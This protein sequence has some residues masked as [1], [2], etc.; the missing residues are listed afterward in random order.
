[1]DDLE[2]DFLTFKINCL[3]NSNVN[4][5]TSG[6]TE[7]I[8][9]VSTIPD[10][11]YKTLLLQKIKQHLGV[12]NENLF[13]QKNEVKKK[14]L[15][16]IEHDPI[17]LLEREIIRLLL[18]YFNSEDE[19]VLIGKYILQETKD[20]NL[21]NS[22]H[23]KILEIIASLPE[24]QTFNDV[25]NTADDQLRSLMID[26]VAVKYEISDCWSDKFF[27]EFSTEGDCLFKN[28]RRTILMLK[29]KVIQEMIGQYKES[30]KN[31]S[32][33]QQIDKILKEISTLKQYE[34]MI[35]NEIKN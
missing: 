17:E 9:L 3:K 10:D 33:D 1:M 20:V 35:F 25:F 31:I 7:L 22:D 27:R 30:L 28:A 24:Q 2:T 21:K 13:I 32:D 18:L 11:I 14:F 15:S 12:Q 8:N 26:I 16:K 19:G 29:R 5:T 23:K 4:D 34:I 6:V